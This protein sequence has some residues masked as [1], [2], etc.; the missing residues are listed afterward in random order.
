MDQG[1]YYRSIGYTIGG[2]AV[3]FYY[4]AMRTHKQTRQTEICVCGSVCWSNL[5]HDPVLAIQAI[6]N[7]TEYDY[8]RLGPYPHRM[9]AEKT[10]VDMSMKV[11]G[12]P[13]K[14]GLYAVAGL[15]ELPPGTSRQP[16]FW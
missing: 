6:K 15:T 8:T 2:G 7:M 16:A 1:E 14:Y 9:D 12:V 10:A 4:V 13:T 3:H 5:N 11:H